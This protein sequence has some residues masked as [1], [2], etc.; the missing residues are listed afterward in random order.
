MANSQ[1]RQT[2]LPTFDRR[3]LWMGLGLLTLLINAIFRSNPYFTEVVYSRGI[4]LLIRWIWDYSLG[5]IPIPLLYVFSPLFIFYFV[6]RWRKGRVHRQARPWKNRVGSLVISLLG[7]AGIAVF[8]FYFLWGFNY[9]RLPV[10][11]QLKLELSELTDEEV[12][13]EY[14]RV[15]AL[16]I[17]AHDDF[18]FQ[19]GDFYQKVVLAKKPHFKKYL[20]PGKGGRSYIDH[21]NEEIREEYHRLILDGFFEQISDSVF[22]TYFNIS[23]LTQQI[24]EEVK[25]Q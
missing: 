10:A 1:F 17:E 22:K 21:M 18:N 14:E 24:R 11:Q 23:E 2:G 6:R 5:L 15:T 19:N 9:Q 4:F 3:Y 13:A 8:L 12:V 20:K 7:F 16:M 25:S